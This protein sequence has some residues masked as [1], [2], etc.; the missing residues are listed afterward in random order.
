MDEKT[1][2]NSEA[3]ENGDFELLS[4]F[5]SYMEAILG[6]SPLTCREYRYDLLLFFRFLRASA[7][8]SRTSLPG[9]EEVAAARTDDIG[10]EEIRQVRLS[11]CYRFLTWLTRARSASAANRA[12]KVAALRAFF[13]YL[14]SNRQLLDR[15]PTL[16][17]ETPR[18]AKRL[19]R[20]LNL[21]ES[22]R[23]LDRTGEAD[24]RFRTRNYCILTL[25][26]NCG[27]RLSELCGIDL[28][29]IS[30][31]T[32][33]VTGKGNRERTIYL[34]RACLEALNA[35]YPD[36][37]KLPKRTAASRA[38]FIS[39]QGNRLSASAVQH[40]IRRQLVAAGLDPRRYSTH[41]LRHTAA[42]LMY[43]HGHVDIRMLQR[44]LGHASVA[45]T[46]IYTHL[47]D[48][49]LHDAVASNPLANHSLPEPV[50]GKPD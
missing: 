34:N 6:R 27:L 41:K 29:D 37:G 46:E 9:E 15:N 14:S 38:L 12:R 10:L 19:P 21:E 32:L 47:D 45:T 39:R 40:M 33:R 1:P 20:H 43:Q 26:L 2:D 24:T 44:I 17:L 48:R 3:G 11:D 31:D 22:A 42:T 16:E 28:D 30:D 49:S 35:W 25:F 36:R 5:I 8:H 23:L 50:D 4:D 7:A 18:Q 13:R